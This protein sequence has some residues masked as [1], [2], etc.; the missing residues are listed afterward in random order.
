MSQYALRGLIVQLEFFEIRHETFGMTN[1]GAVIMF[2]PPDAQQSDPF[3]PI[4]ITR[5][6]IIDEYYGKG[7]AS[8]RDEN[9]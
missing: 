1:S 6:Q 2:R 8:L 9:S 5:E 7:V 4:P 3:I